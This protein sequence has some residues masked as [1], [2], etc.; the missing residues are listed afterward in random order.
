M[1]RLLLVAAPLRCKIIQ[2]SSHMTIQLAQLPVLVRCKTAQ[3][4]KVQTNLKSIVW[5]ATLIVII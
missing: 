4:N 1:Y 5:C 3:S 2:P